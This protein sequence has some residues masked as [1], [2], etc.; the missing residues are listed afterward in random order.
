MME[1]EEGD[2]DE[3]DMQNFPVVLLT[4]TGEVVEE[5]RKMERRVVRAV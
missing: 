3:M 1:E 5:K 4:R 2:K